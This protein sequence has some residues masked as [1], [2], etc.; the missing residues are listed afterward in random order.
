MFCRKDMNFGGTRGGMLPPN[1][2]VEALNPSV[3]MFGYRTSKEVIKVKGVHRSSTIS[4]LGRRDT[5]ELACT[6]SPLVHTH[7]G[8]T[9]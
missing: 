5:R 9:T 3:V 1:S 7:W 4:G 6:L 2:L 8:N